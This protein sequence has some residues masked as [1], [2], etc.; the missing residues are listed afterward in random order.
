MKTSDPKSLGRIVRRPNQ[1]LRQF[2]SA[3]AIQDDTGTWVCGRGAIIL[4]DQL[5]LFLF[6]CFL[7]WAAFLGPREPS[8][9]ASS[10]RTWDTSCMTMLSLMRNRTC[11]IPKENVTGNEGY[12]ALEMVD[13]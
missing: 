10:D 5:Q 12:I 7:L 11:E 8:R 1:L 6:H 4:D 9:V 2:W 13:S 3:R